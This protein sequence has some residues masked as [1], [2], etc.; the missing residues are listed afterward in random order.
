MDFALPGDMDGADVAQSIGGYLH[1]AV[2]LIMLSGQ[3]SSVSLPWLPG[4]PLLCLW[5][6]MDAEVLLEAVVAFARLGRFM[7]THR[8]RVPS[9]G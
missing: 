9:P 1:R 3:L 8:V 5:K 4:A 7:Q 2:P 6:P